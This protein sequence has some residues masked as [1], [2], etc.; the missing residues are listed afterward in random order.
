MFVSVLYLV[1][2]IALGLR[3]NIIYIKKKILSKVLIGVQ[4]KPFLIVNKFRGKKKK[5]KFQ[6]S[7]TDVSLKLLLYNPH[8]SYYT[9]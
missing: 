2:I 3:I 5:N 9:V 6:T 7:L 8:I 1:F 4:N